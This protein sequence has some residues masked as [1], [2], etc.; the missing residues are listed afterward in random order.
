MKKN[1]SRH[2]MHMANHQTRK[3]TAL[4][5]ENFKFQGRLNDRD[6]NRNSLRRAR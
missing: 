2:E 4:T 5:W 3:E 1:F 6:F